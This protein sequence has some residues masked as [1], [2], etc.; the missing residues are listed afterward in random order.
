MIATTLARRSLWRRGALG[1]GA[2][3]EQKRQT[4]AD[5]RRETD[6]E[7]AHPDIL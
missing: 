4:A 5:H 2:R 6:R 3:H 7:S 1:A